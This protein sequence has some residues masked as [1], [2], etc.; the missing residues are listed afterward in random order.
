MLARMQQ[1]QNP[2]AGLVP[3]KRPTIVAVKTA[4]KRKPKAKE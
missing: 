3:F 4:A 2:G 1:Q